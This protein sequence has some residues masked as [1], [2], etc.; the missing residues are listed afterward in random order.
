[1][2]QKHMQLEMYMHSLQAHHIIQRARHCLLAR[3]QEV[4]LA[5]AARRC[6]IRQDLLQAA[7]SHRSCC[8][9]CMLLSLVH[10]ERQHAA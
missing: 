3:V 2:K 4:K 10:A 5:V 6:W 9:D 7:S 8:K 1:M